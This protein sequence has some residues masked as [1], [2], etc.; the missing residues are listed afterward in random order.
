[1]AQVLTQP[2]H[3]HTP[4]LSISSF[5]QFNSCGGAV[6]LAE[7]HP[8]LLTQSVTSSVNPESSI[9][10]VYS[11]GLRTVHFDRL[12]VFL[13]ILLSSLTTVVSLS[14]IVWFYHLHA[15]PQQTLWHNS[16]LRKKFKGEHSN[17][18]IEVWDE[19]EKRLCYVRFSTTILRNYSKRLSILVCTVLM[20]SNIYDLKFR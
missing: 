1:M 3:H 6:F 2:F 8:Q 16:V 17:T 18:S 7:S 9:G 11:S 20:L 14:S 13:L 19:K 12:R 15:Y 4:V 10:L 5:V